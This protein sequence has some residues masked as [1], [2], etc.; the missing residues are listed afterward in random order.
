MW[1]TVLVVIMIISVGYTLYKEKILR[2]GMWSVISCVKCCVGG[3][4]LLM[5]DETPTRLR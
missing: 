3:P 5:A 4:V 2:M 1:F